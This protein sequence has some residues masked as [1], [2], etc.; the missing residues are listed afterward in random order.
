M[1]KTLKIPILLISILILLF[2][3]NT[4]NHD[5]VLDDFSVVKENFVVKKGL[6]GIPTIWKTPYRYGY[7][8]QNTELYRPLSLTL[9]ALQWE[10]APD[11]PSLAHAFNIFLY[12]LLCILIYFF[13]RKILGEKGEMIAF[14]ATMIFAAHPIHTEVVA[15]IKSMDE[16]L[17]ACFGLSAYLFLL[18]YLKTDSKRS[19]FFSLLFILLGFFA[20]ESMISLLFS[21]PLIL[22]FLQKVKLVKTLKISSLYLIPLGIYLTIRQK[23]L[24]QLSD[25]GQMIKLDNILVAA[26]D[27]LTE[28]ATAIKILG[29]YLW[30]L[31]VPH[32]LVY[33]YSYSELELTTFHD[34]LVWLSAFTYL[35]LIYLVFR[36]RKQSPLLSFGIGFY[37]INL[38]LYSNLFFKIGTS[39]GERLLFLPSLGFALVLAELIAKV[40]KNRHFQLKKLKPKPQ[41]ILLTFI[42]LI[43]GFKTI[44]RNPAWKDNF[45]LYSADLKH[46]SNSARCQ[47][48]MGLGFMKDRGMQENNTQQRAIY[49]E[50]AVRHFNRAVKIYPDYSDAWGQKGLAHYR[51]NQFSTAEKAYLKSIEINPGNAT[52]HSN[53]GSLYFKTEQFNAAKTAFEKALQYQ[54]NHIDAN[55]NYA[56]TLG[57]LGE[58]E[59]AIIYFK[60]AIS[61][62]PNR[63]NYYQMLAATYQNMGNQEKANAYFRKAKMISAN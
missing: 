38:S 26:N 19:I 53:L 11:Q 17:A 45:T 58:Y 7:G 29:L 15:N 39:F 13:L 21:I 48:F 16:L 24:G 12:L 9:F 6:E 2:Y 49:L 30:K 33:D 55:A 52:T 36:F 31:I 57:T 23:V 61:L 47:Y 50:K 42:V 37:L 20:K 22:I 40:G 60:K 46:C 43:Y 44:Q 4:L 63:A 51:L 41:F 27:Q 35:T 3:S 34:P 8:F 25:D 54:P 62:E 56:A 14:Y 1:K 10:I 5:Y 28:W 18:N 32:P 59:K